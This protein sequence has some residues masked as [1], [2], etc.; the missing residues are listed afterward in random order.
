MRKGNIYS[1]IPDRAP[2]EIFETLVD[3]ERVS[4]QRII[5]GS[6]CSPDGFWYDHLGTQ[7]N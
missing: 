6:H 3:S 7:E 5:S 2:E 4:V 1:A